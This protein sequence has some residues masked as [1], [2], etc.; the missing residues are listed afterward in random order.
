VFGRGE[1]VPQFEKEAY[2]AKVGAIV[3]PFRT[4]FGWHVLR[5][6]DHVPLSQEAPDRALEQIRERLYANEIEVQ[7]NN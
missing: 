4:E 6:D 7:F 3:G 1:M 2:K 5:V